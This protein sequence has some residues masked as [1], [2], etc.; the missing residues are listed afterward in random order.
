ME[1]AEVVKL[2]Q[3]YRHDLMNHLQIVQGYISMNNREK[4]EK[5]LKETIR[6]YEN[7]RKLMNL[8]VPAFTLWLMQVNNLF[9]HIKL[10]YHVLTEKKL[11][12]VD[13]DLVSKGNK[14]IS[15]INN[16][17]NKEELLEIS[18]EI[19]DAEDLIFPQVNYVI[20]GQNSREMV[21]KRNLND[22][23]VQVKQTP[24]GIIC[25]FLIQ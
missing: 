9:N 23:E 18:M 2:L 24:A 3:Q 19:K 11:Y 10:E 6:H 22:D 14:I 5:K 7:E 16:T 12:H 8:K 4:A 13:H 17:Y 20:Q 25:S 15:A 1:D 21:L